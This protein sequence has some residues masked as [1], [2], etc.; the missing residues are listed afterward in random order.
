MK[1]LYYLICTIL[2]CS[3]NFY[4]SCDNLFSP[5]DDAYI[6]T[7]IILDLNNFIIKSI[8]KCDF[9][10]LVTILD[11]IKYPNN[12]FPKLNIE[13]KNKFLDLIAKKIETETNSYNSG[14]TAKEK[15]KLFVNSTYA[16]ICLLLQILVIKDFMSIEL[17]RNTPLRLAYHLYIFTPILFSSTLCFFEN[18]RFIITKQENQINIDKL[19]HMHSILSWA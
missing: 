14:Y 12:I 7:N 11:K 18:L 19:K 9:K 10:L 1:K 8:N 17:N 6:E 2:I 15:R 4:S 5:E 3:I 13:N 16:S